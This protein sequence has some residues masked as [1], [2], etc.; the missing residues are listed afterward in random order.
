VAVCSSREWRRCLTVASAIGSRSHGRTYPHRRRESGSMGCGPPRPRQRDQRTRDAYEAR[1]RG[2]DVEATLP[3]TQL[4][5]GEIPLV[6]EAARI[7]GVERP[8]LPEPVK[9]TWSEPA[10]ADFYSYVAREMIPAPTIQKVLDWYTDLVVV[11]GRS[12]TGFRPEDEHTAREFL[13]QAGLTTGQT[14]TLI[15]WHKANMR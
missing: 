12:V 13:G 1:E 6:G 7:A 9:E 15:R 2:S 4:V 5:A 14:E 10:E 8:T 3:D 11:G